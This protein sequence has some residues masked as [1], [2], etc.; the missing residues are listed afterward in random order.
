MVDH[1]AL[2]CR[3][4]IRIIAFIFLSFFIIP[5]CG[6]IQY[7]SR[8]LK[9]KETQG[10]KYV[11][12]A[13]ELQL[14]LDDL[15]SVFAGVIEQSADL[16]I[17]ESTKNEVV[18][19]ALL[20]KINGIPTAYRALFHSDPAIAILDTWAFSMQMVNYFNN[21]DGKK[22]FGQWYKIAHASSLKLE[23]KLEQLVASGLPDGNID[24]LRQ[25][26]RSWVGEHPIARDF[27]YRYTIVPELGKIIS[28]Q[29][30]DT[31]QTVGS[32]A[33]GMEEMS[34]QIAA[35]MNLLTKQ[36]KWQAQLTLAETFNHKDPQD[37][38]SKLVDLADSLNKMSPAI[39]QLPNLIVEERK[40]FL[41]VLQNEREAILKSIDEQRIATI[42][43]INSSSNRMIES[44]IGQ[45]K[46]LI[47]H[48]FIRTFQFIALFLVGLLIV[49]VL[50]I[51][52]KNK[53]DRTQI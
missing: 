4:N 41:E 23:K 42:A 30:L 10:A 25:D 35:H 48:F 7:K 29:E 53:L 40:T 27:V 39:A 11:K 38:I 43:E 33:V 50:I 5:E 32:L 3:V 45:S 16:V 28:D 18:Q 17:K 20:W 49:A 15:V 9:K 22:D 14:Y 1:K 26:F 44:T 8:L 31:L 21:G 47:D 24:S 52:I 13:L 6:A 46:Q 36:A 34:D 2:E 19:H 37:A 12:S 51:H